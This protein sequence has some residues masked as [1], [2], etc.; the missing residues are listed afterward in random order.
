MGWPS[1]LNNDSLAKRLT[2]NE[3]VDAYERAIRDLRDGFALVARAER[4]LNDTFV[5]D[6]YGKIHIHMHRDRV[7]FDAPDETTARIEKQVWAALVERLEVKRMMSIHRVKELDDAIEKGEMSPISI[8]NVTAFATGISNALPDMLVEAVRE[9]YNW[10]RPAAGWHGSHYKTNQK[11]AR[12]E[13][14]PKVILSGMVESGWSGK[15]PFHVHYH[16]TDKLR[17]LDNVFS[18][19]D[20]KGQISKTYYGPLADAINSSPTGRGETDYF[21]FKA[22][23]NRN[24]HLEFKRLDLVEHFNALAGGK[25][26]RDH[27]RR[28]EQ[29]AP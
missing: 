24:L 1:V 15:I 28:D 3:A 26:L 29:D 18:A 10:L 20:G 4:L 21:R 12:F 7:D 8:E 27:D 9:V 19:L 25:N 14:G 2:V 17:A 11:N 13:L 16:C 5:L 22:F 23:K 6:H